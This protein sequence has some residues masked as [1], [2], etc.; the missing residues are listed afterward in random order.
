MRS[1]VADLK[2]QLEDRN[3]DFYAWCQDEMMISDILTKEKKEKF[4]LDGLIRDNRL[5]ILL[6]RDNMVTYSELD[7]DYIIS[8]RRL[9]DKI[10]PRKGPPMRKKL[11]TGAGIKT[12]AGIKTGAGI[13][14]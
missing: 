4:G 6:N 5:E 10:A 11:K 9:R 14:K 1:D 7:N 3:V 2:Q 12:E 8:G 13:K